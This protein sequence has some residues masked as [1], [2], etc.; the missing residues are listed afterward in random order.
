MV[1]QEQLVDVSV[2]RLLRNLRLIFCC[3]ESSWAQGLSGQGKQNWLETKIKGEEEM[4][5]ILDIGVY[6]QCLRRVFSPRKGS[7]M[8]RNR[9]ILS[10]GG[11]KQ[12]ICHVYQRKTQC[13][14]D[15]NS[16]PNN[17]QIQ[18]NSNEHPK[19]LIFKCIQSRTLKEQ[20]R[21][22]GFCTYKLIKLQSLR[23]CALGKDKKQKNRTDKTE[24]PETDLYI[25]SYVI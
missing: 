12:E 2:G 14:Q 10:H 13:L 17:L 11:H 20:S 22:G 21:E 3:L 16:P 15:V 6:A 5:I 23:W 4:D 25:Y 8:K 1:S 19:K 18:C 9:I 7:S 24:S